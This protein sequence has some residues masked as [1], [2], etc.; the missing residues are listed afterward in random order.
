MCV[1]IFC[2]FSPDSV[3][4]LIDLQEEMEDMGLEEKEQEQGGEDEER[5]PL[6]N[7]ARTTFR[8]HSGVCR[9][10]LVCLISCICL[11]RFSILCVSTS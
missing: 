8:G 4:V 6:R 11:T 2:V 3:F 5:V 10:N 1:I 7:D 9:H